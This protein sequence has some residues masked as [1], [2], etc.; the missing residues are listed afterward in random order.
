MKEFMG[1]VSSLSYR[2]DYIGVH[3][4]TQPDAAAFKTRITSIYNL[5]KKPIIPTEFAVADYN[6]KTIAS[7]R[8]LP[9][10]VSQFMKDIIC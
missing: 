4:Y 7:N 3:E 8:Y 6:A 10:A 2:V 5:Y 9:D 1:N